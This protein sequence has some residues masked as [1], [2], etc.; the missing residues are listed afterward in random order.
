MITTD[1][2]DEAVARY[3]RERD[4]YDKLVTIATEQCLALI[5]RKGI[6]ATVGGRSK[7]PESL[8]KKL[9]KYQRELDQRYTS[10]D[11]VFACMPDLAA[12][13]ITTY[14]ES[15]R[16]LVQDEVVKAFDLFR[17]PDMKDSPSAA[18]GKH[19]RAIHCWASLRISEVDDSPDLARLENIA[20]TRFEIQICSM[21]A[22][23]WNEIEHDIGYKPEGERPEGTVLDSLEILGQLVRAGDHVIHAL[24]AADQARVRTADDDV[25]F[26][27]DRDFEQ[28]MRRF[29]PDAENFSWYSAQLFDALL[30][31]RLDSPKRIRGELLG[32]DDRYKQRAADLVAKVNSHQSGARLVLALDP[33]TSDLLAALLFDKK[34]EEFLAKHPTGRGRGRPSRLVSIAK[35]FQ[36]MRDSHTAS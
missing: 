29:F 10:V 4:R 8:R 2:I 19:Y 16:S 27:S 14:L 36:W 21:L 9:L 33:S 11:D 1:Q 32:T 30:E 28:R 25:P 5:R 31:L 18:R 7:T 13:R 26:T 23:V 17:A 20:E 6:R 15:D 34:L 3:E 24:I 35:R 12:V 22:H